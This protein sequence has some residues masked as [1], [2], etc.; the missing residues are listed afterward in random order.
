[1]CVGSAPR[2]PPT[3]ARPGP[4]DP[5]QLGK[6][7]EPWKKSWEKAPRRG[8]RPPCCFVSFSFCDPDLLCSQRG[9]R[10]LGPRILKL[11]GG[12]DPSC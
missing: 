11:K 2:P 10:T 5:P 8:R 6:D 4:A 3:R 7:D 12:L 1:M 9:E